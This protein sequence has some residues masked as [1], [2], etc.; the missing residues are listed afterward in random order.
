MRKRPRPPKKGA[1]EVIKK[2]T[3]DELQN[4]LLHVVGLL[5]SIRDERKTL[6]KTL[7]SGFNK[8]NDLRLS[9]F[10]GMMKKFK[11]TPYEFFV[12]LESSLPLPSKPIQMAYF[13]ITYQVTIDGKQGPTGT[14]GATPI[15]NPNAVKGRLEKIFR[16][17]NPDAKQVAIVILNKEKVD[18][19]TYWEAQK[20][21][22]P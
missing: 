13:V 5:K 8:S 11:M 4:L 9:T 19:D 10:L 15:Y 6:K 7:Y 1:D 21:F 22:N 20:G 2:I 16:E 17:K 14:Q 3:D 18:K 12:L